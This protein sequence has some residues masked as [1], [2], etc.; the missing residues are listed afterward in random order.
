MVLCIHCL[1]DASRLLALRR[2]RNLTH[3]EAPRREQDLRFLESGYHY[4]KLGAGIIRNNSAAHFDPCDT[5]DE[6]D[7]HSGRGLFENPGFHLG[8]IQLEQ[9]MMEPSSTP[10]MSNTQNDLERGVEPARSE[11]TALR[12]RSLGQAND[13]D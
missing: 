8:F 4:A 11:V 12:V 10:C 13:L 2:A 7:A 3:K 5:I 1:I 6:K 9:I